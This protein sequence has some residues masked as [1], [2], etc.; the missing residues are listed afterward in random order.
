MSLPI[1]PQG[2]S[3]HY[4]LNKMMVVSPSH[5]GY[6]GEVKKVSLAPATI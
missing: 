6:F 4:A 2:K 3:Y 5:S 1:Y